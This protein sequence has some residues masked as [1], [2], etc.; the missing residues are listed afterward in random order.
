[1]PKMYGIF[2]LFISLCTKAT[3]LNLHIGKP[4]PGYQCHA[5]KNNKRNHSRD[6]D[7]NLGNKKKY[8]CKQDSVLVLL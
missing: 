7:Q 4:L 8:M 1:M 2:I 6:Y 5:I 3:Y